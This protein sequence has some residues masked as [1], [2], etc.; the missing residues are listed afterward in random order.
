MVAWEAT[1]LP[2]GYARMLYSI[3]F[4]RQ[5]E[6]LPTTV[7]CVFLF[8]IPQGGVFDGGIRDV[9]SYDSRSSFGVKMN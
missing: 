3:Q 8:R 6:N 1:A 7:D 5:P 9:E 4:Y 2:L